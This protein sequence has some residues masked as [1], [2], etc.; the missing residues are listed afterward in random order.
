MLAS[1]PG[2]VSSLL[3][4]AL[5]AL[6]A[7]SNAIPTSLSKGHVAALTPEAAA[8]EIHDLPGM[9]AGVTFRQFSGDPS[10]FFFPAPRR[11]PCPTK[12]DAGKAR[13]DSIS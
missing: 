12:M 3:A 4:V 8:D 6:L 1:A 10:P 7:S 9:P 11:V 5:L 13:M 2:G